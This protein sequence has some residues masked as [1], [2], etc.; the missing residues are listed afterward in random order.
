[1]KTVFLGLTIL[2]AL[3]LT[4]CNL[5][6]PKPTSSSPTLEPQAAFWQQVGS[7]VYMATQE[8]SPLYDL[9]LTGSNAPVIAYTKYPTLTDDTGLSDGLYVRVWT[10]TDWGFYAS[11][12]IAGCSLGPCGDLKIAKNPVGGN[13]VV[14]FTE[15]VDDAG[16][17][18]LYVRYL[19]ESG[20]VSYGAPLNLSNG[21]V[22]NIDLAVAGD[23]NPVVAW[24]ESNGDGG[25]LLYVRK[26]DGSDWVP[27]DSNGFNINNYSCS[28]LEGLSLSLESILVGSGSNPIVAWSESNDCASPGNTSLDIFVKR[29]DGTTWVDYGA[30]EALDVVATADA[31]SPSLAIINTGF[32]LQPVVAWHE[33]DGF[34]SNVYVKQWNGSAW[35]TLGSFTGDSP[36]LAKLNNETGLVLSFNF[37]GAVVIQKLQG[38]SWIPL[39]GLPN[40]SS[41]YPAMVLD[42]TG[43][44]FIALE[45]LP[46][47]ERV[48]SV[49]Q[50][51][52]QSWQPLASALDSD[53]NSNADTPAIDLQ[54]DN[55]PVVAFSEFSDL[56]SSND[57][58]VKSW[59]ASTSSW[60]FLGDTVEGEN[61]EAFRP[62]LALKSNN[63]P[64]VGWWKKDD[65]Y[66]FLN[67]SGWDGST[68][69]TY[70][71][72]SPASGPEFEDVFT[73]S[74]ALDSS[75]T[76]VI[77]YANYSYEGSDYRLV[78]RV[79]KWDAATSTWVSIGDLLNV[80][81]GS[82]NYPSLALDSSN[83]PVVAWQETVGTSSNIYVKRWNT[84]TS[85]WDSLGTTLDRVRASNAVRPSLV[86]RTDGQPVV[87]FEETYGGSQD[88][89]V[90]RWTGT[91]WQ[92]LRN[93][94]ASVSA[95]VT[96]GA[97]AVTPHL[98]IRSDNVPV[99]TFEQ[100][101]N[102]YVRRFLAN[103]WRTVEGGILDRNAANAASSPVVAVKSN[104]QPTVVWV[105]DNSSNTDVFVSSY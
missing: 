89:Y 39:G 87:A 36:S 18:L 31:S 70:G 46:L 35:I 105:E 80:G 65:G 103:T 1:M 74:L 40:P 23:Q 94:S 85:A 42:N 32:S 37:D 97:D 14:A 27:F 3:L 95:D 13:P 9:E 71:D 50:W 62:V 99:L 93:S 98:A 34:A 54:S 66:V 78:I 83:N 15:F 2:W 59:N 7:S 33:S 20:W 81:T 92:F 56:G 41:S 43:Q 91:S 45:S 16:Y 30:G 6:L 47:D 19:S 84:A 5:T 53:V 77:A 88:V 21:D 25:Y 104:K 10:G 101:D 48:L 75:D 38:S 11:D 102:I 64:V 22:T 67:V 44:P 96:P 58:L 90:R 100:D 17:H 51:R 60:S 52:T 63:Q 61:V 49:N 55:S 76:P 57:V 4:S 26:W 82:V 79:K 29:F 69:S 8:Y 24:S 73:A 86:L 12:N 72:S 68:W 28:S